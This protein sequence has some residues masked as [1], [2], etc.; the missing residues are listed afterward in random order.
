M[1]DRV[2]KFDPDWQEG[3][4]ATKGLEYQ[5]S[6]RVTQPP[7]GSI[8]LRGW[9]R[10]ANGSERTLSARLDCVER[11]LIGATFIDDH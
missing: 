5:L 4:G 3:S 11:S 6:L 9:T 10:G 8:R 7:H 1:D 2:H